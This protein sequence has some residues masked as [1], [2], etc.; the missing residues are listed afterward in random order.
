[1]NVSVT[2]E[3][4]EFVQRLVASGRYHSASEVFREGLRLLENSE[5]RRLM[6]KW[7]FEGLTA[8]EG[9]Q[10]P[11]KVL[12]RLQQRLEEFL[13][14]GLDELDRGEGLDGEQVFQEL[15][16]RNRRRRTASGT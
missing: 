11:P 2:P 5:R 3:L 7:L 16:D 13:Q 4:E 1:M 10:L 6:E 12:E 14:P 9:A 8:E 15:L